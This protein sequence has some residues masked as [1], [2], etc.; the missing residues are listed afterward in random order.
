MIAV[1]LLA[2]VAGTCQSDD[3]ADD[4][5]PTTDRTTTT[6]SP[7]AEVEAAY[8][9]YWD[10]L[11]RLA[12]A[13]DPNDPEI[14]Q[15]ASGKALEEIK[16]GLAN[17]LSLGR[18]AHPG[19]EY[20][21]AVLSVELRGTGAVVRDCAIDDSTIIDQATGEKVGGGVPATGLLEASLLADGDEWRIDSLD[22]LQ[23]WSGVVTCEE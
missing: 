3:D 4:T 1:A 18:V 15:R 10:M 12:A 11:G 16:A 7:E 13:P 22:T 23:T 8:L 2:L 5:S 21:H 17:Q 20:S 6:V 14:D 19:P 9:A